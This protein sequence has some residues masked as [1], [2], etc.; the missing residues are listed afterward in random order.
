MGVEGGRM[1]K[2]LA[3]QWSVWY[4]NSNT[5]EQLSGSGHHLP[6]LFIWR[7]DVQSSGTDPTAA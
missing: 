3:I 2:Y 1:K 5:L 4:L 6:T 7:K